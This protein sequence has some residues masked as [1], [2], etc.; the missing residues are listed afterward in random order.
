LSGAQSTFIP[1]LSLRVIERDGKPWFVAADVCKALALSDT[2]MFLKGLPDAHK[3]KLNLGLRGQAPWLVSKAGLFRLVMKSRKPEAEDGSYV[4]GEE[5]VA[6]GEMT[7]D[8][9]V[10]K[11]MVS[12]QTKVA[13]LAAQ[14]KGLDHPHGGPGADKRVDARPALTPLATS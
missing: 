13:R 3:A 2:N 6:T 10:L 14:A 9:L 11:A 7:E 1:G 12:L 4:Q 8:E 5:Q